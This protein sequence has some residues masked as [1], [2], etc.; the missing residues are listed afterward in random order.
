MKTLTNGEV[1][2]RVN[3]HGTE[4]YSLRCNGR[5]YLWQGDPAYWKRRSPL[6]FPIVGS[7]WDGKYRSNNKVYEMGQHG[8]ARD[9]DFTM[10]DD[11]PDT[12]GH[13]QVFYALRS[14][15]E[16]LKRYPYR[17]RL[18]IGYRLLG[19]TVEVIWR[20]QNPDP[21]R[22]L[23]FQIGAHP[24]F[25]WPLL[26][27]QDIEAGTQAQEATLA[28]HHKRGSFAF[29]THKD[30]LTRSV[31]TEKGCI[32]PSCP[33]PLPLQPGGILPLSTETFRNDAIVLENN[34]VH[35]VT[36]RD[37]SDRPYLSLS[38]NAPLVGLWSPPGKNAPFVCI[39]PWYGR[40]DHV[41]FDGDYEQK[42]WIQ[43][44]APRKTFEARYQIR[45][46]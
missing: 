26:S 1:T 32:D 33:A 37:E 7:V 23:F 5:E 40:C 14:S 43:S 46:E 44:L 16:T 29:D 28:R 18:E 21:E 39:E 17:F 12:E 27:N 45:I 34:Q 30:E 6:L 36:L 20:V 4:L 9:M 42:D 38:F 11:A 41:R 13:P 2:I 35:H 3:D 19:R 25:Y 15:T 22:E 31:I 8:F 24:A 10:I